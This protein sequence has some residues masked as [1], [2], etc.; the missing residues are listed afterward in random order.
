MADRP[1]LFSAPMIRALLD[2]RKT[3]TRR[4]LKPQPIEHEGMN[5]RRLKFVGRDGSIV[6]DASPDLLSDGSCP[7]AIFTRY[8]PGDRLYVREDWSTHPKYDAIA[9]RDLDR[10]TGLYTRADMEWHVCTEVIGAPFGRRRA[11]MHMPRWA[12]R[13]TLLV[14]EVKVERLQDISEEDAR[15][16]GVEM[17]ANRNYRDGFAILWNSINGPDAW[18]ANPWVVVIQ[19]SVRRG[20][21]DR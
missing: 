5:C 9:P 15:A 4:V 6:G 16:E 3:Q 12:S 21:I 13:L 14:D 17:I 7:A 2:G 20:N 19:F 18:D 11:G 8:A 1:I 10:G